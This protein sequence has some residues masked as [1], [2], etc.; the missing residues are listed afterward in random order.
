MLI[1]LFIADATKGMVRLWRELHIHCAMTATKN[2]GQA[3]V[4]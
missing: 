3:R 2:F 1:L 4:Y